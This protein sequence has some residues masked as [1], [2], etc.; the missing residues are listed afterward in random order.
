V[1]NFLLLMLIPMGI[2]LVTLFTFRKRIHM[3]EFALQLAVPAVFVGFGLLLSYYQSTSDVE[4][5]NGRVASKAKVRVSCSHSY[6]CN[7]RTIRSGKS[8]TTVCS[9]CYEHSHDFDWR[10]ISNYGDTTNISRINRQG[11]QEPPRWSQVFVGEP[12]SNMNSYTNYILANPDSVLLGGKGDIE[13]FKSLLPP[14]YP[15]TYDYYRSNHFVPLGFG[16][17]EIPDRTSWEW[18]LREV[19]ADLGPSKQVNVLLLVAKTRHS[20]YITALKDHWIGGKKND[21]LVVVGSADGHK[22]DFADVL[23]WTPN[24]LFKVKLRDRLLDIGT[25]DRRDDV[26]SAIKTTV[27]EDFVRMNM[28]DFEYL[29]RSFQPS[30][31]AMIFLFL[32]ASATSIGLAVWAVKNDTDCDLERPHRRYTFR[33]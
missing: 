19:N 9:T 7:C 32:L 24:Q 11:T 17:N 26:V 27:N 30:N 12:Y 20:E 33:N 22:I 13:R 29:V 8:T 23:S 28:K 31:G 15:S 10:V 6:R 16:G 14:D 1:I 18:L 21:V 3:G 2:A 5:L 4:M 25:L